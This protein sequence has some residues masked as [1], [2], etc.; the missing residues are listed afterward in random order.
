MKTLTNHPVV[1]DRREFMSMLAVAA[2]AGTA[3][4]AGNHDSPGV[5]PTIPLGR[6]RIS[7]LISGSN[8]IQGY[9]YLG[10]HTDRQMRDYFTPEQT[11]AFLKDCEHA[12]ITTH[13]FGHSERSVEYVGRL[14]ATGSRIQLI[15]LHSKREDLQAAVSATRPIAVAHHGGVTD[16][17]FAE[18]KADVVH[19]YVKAV[20]DMGLTAGVSAHNPDCI[21]KIA[22]AGWDVDFFMTCFYFLTRKGAG[23]DAE[24]PTLQV[25]YPFFKQDPQV[26]T[27]VIRQVDQTCLA[28]KVLGAGRLCSSPETVRAA[29][30]FAFENIKPG[31]GVIVGMFP[32]Y[33]DEVNANA[34]YAREF[35][36]G[37][38]AG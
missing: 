11:L 33:F 26:M 38:S 5:M 36:S 28:F 10:S 34:Q 12:G 22:D 31:D 24:T 9:S 2:S 1:P 3:A 17:L 7:R 25:S 8:P 29:F 16:R 35:S 23:L 20:R 13:Q 15:C 32:R 30:Q 18:G 27:E 21:R 37:S 19:D 14:Q 4:L 6:H